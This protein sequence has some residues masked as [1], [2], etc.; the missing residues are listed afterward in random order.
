MTF[1]RFVGLAA[2]TLLLL[3][4]LCF[5]G[6]GLGFITGGGTQTS[7]GVA[8]LLI[9]VAILVGAFMLFRVIL[10]DAPPEQE[11]GL[12]LKRRP[13]PPPPNEPPPEA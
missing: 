13:P 1:G 7:G 2:A 5:F 9:G 6:F 12:G 10:R 4:G 8:L 11:L 3:P